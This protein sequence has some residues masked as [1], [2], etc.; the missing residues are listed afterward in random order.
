MGASSDSTPAGLG[1]VTPG[2]ITP[3]PAG[4]T[5]HVVK[6]G[7]YLWDLA[8]KYNTSVKSIQEANGLTSDKIIIGQTLIIPGSA[9]ATMPSATN[10][11]T[12]ESATMPSTVQTVPS[13]PTAPA[14]APAP[15]TT[16]TTPTTPA[17]GTTVPT[18]LP[19]EPPSLQDANMPSTTV[20]TTPSVPSVPS[21]P[22]ADT[23]PPPPSTEVQVPGAGFGVP[24][25]EPSAPS[26]FQ[27]NPG[28]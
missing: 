23:L 19:P 2:T 16:T 27:I 1:A 12:T 8:T 7:D 10:P 3:A 5:T 6:E 22:G 14:P 26:G 15:S 9:S 18:T 20:P 25:T 11:V 28:E 24:P 21:L 17:A 4:G 13:S